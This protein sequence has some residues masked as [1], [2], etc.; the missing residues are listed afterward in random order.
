MGGKFP[1]QNAPLQKYGLL[2]VRTTSSRFCCCRNSDV[3]AKHQ[4]AVVNCLGS[5]WSYLLHAALVQRLDMVLQAQSPDILVVDNTSCLA[6]PNAVIK[7]T[8]DVGGEDKT[9]A[10]MAMYIPMVIKEMLQ[11]C[12]AM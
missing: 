12:I 2:L 6:M 4:H 9:T 8:P 1:F 10:M 5:S 7:V 3:T 11:V